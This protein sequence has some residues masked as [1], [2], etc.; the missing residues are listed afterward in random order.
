MKSENVFSQLKIDCIR[1]LVGILGCISIMILANALLQIAKQ[2]KP[3]N[4]ITTALKTLGF[5]SMAIYIL[6][7]RTIPLGTR[8]VQ[9][10][11]DSWLNVA[12]ITIIAIVLYCIIAFFLY[13]TKIIAA[14]LFGKWTQNRK[15]GSK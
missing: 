12:F 11:S 5:Y 13:K 4:W 1:L 15:Y 2:L 10:T 14:L 8:I 7:W 6:N 9:K 3:L